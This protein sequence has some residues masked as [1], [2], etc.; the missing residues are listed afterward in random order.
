MG[1]EGLT[2]ILGGG[3]YQQGGDIIGRWDHL[4]E[5]KEQDENEKKNEVTTD[6]ACEKKEEAIAEGSPKVEV[7]KEGAGAAKEEVTD[8]T[9]TE[10]GSSGN[11]HAKP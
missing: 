9:Q 8:G 10:K 7:K 1:T 11:N 2:P 6:H 5:E 4:K 3:G